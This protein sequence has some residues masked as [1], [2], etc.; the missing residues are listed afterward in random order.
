M[1]VR[2]WSEH[3]DVRARTLPFPVSV[4]V[5]FDAPLIA[6]PEVT[7]WRPVDVVQP[8]T[9]EL[10]V[11]TVAPA[12]PA[13]EEANASGRSLIRRAVRILVTAALVCGCVL[14]TLPLIGVP[15]GY[16]TYVVTSG[17]MS[18]HAQ[19][20]DAV[21]LKEASRDDI[22]VGDVIAF[23]PLRSEGLTMHRVID[24]RMV[25]GKL[26]FRTKGDAN[27]TP[28]PNLAPAANMLGRVDARVPG[29]GRALLFATQ[30]TGRM[31][32][33]VVPALFLIAREVLWLLQSRSRVSKRATKKPRRALR[34]SAT[35]AVLVAVSVGGLTVPAAARF[36]DGSAVGTNTIG[37]GQV[38]PPNLTSAVADLILICK[39]TL[40]WTAPA[41]G[42]APDGYDIYRS[43]TNGGPYSLVKHV[44]TVTTTT[45]TAL[46]PSTTYFYVLKSSRSSWRSIN[47][48]Q[49]SATSAFLLCL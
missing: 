29:L 10:P 1:T 12:A 3:A 5:G 35:A 42:V 31:L 26:H 34:R 47:S 37:T 43:T 27:A 45:D 4:P 40:T 8:A 25:D 19:A 16:R 33:V 6:R 9:L 44:G 13:H 49:R 38:N 18:P 39:I 11:D 30:R 7:A 23:H 48:N 17:S 28:D 41:T 15:F 2:T 22:N 24:V 36:T 21:L 46:A 20:G 14:F 32:L